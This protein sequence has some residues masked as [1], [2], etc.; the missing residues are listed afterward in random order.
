MSLKSPEGNKKEVGAKTNIWRISVWNIPQFGKGH[1]STGKKKRNK[2]KQDKY[3]EMHI[4]IS[5]YILIYDSNEYPNQVL[6]TTQKN[7]L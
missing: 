6:K 2:H 7:R 1:K 4:L 5:E 3:K